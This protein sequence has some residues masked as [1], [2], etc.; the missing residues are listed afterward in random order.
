MTT[1]RV[2]DVVKPQLLRWARETAGLVPAEAAK[3]IG[4]KPERLAEW[5]EGGLRPTVAQ[6]RKA[7]NVYR[8]PFAAFFLSEPPAQPAPLHDFRRLPGGMAARLSPELLLEMR[9]ARRRRAVAL[10]LLTDLGHAVPEFPLRARLGDDPEE[11]AAEA[12]TWLGV[13]RD[14]QARWAGEYEPLTAWLT[15]LEA[16]GVLV[17]QTSD[18]PL[19]EMRGFSLNERRLPVI[20]LNAKDAPRGR[21]F[22][23]MH[24]F[25]HLILSQGGVCDP[26][27]L[28]RHARTDDERIEVYCN[29]VA[30]AILVPRD[31]LVGHPVVAP[32]RGP[33]E[34]S[35]E[36]LQQLTDEFAVSREVVLRRLL[37]LGRTTDEFYERK[38]RQYLAQ[39]QALASR[40]RE[41]EGFAPLFRVVVRDNGRRYTRLVLEALDRERITLADVS[42]YLGV[43]LKHLDDIA[44]AV[45]R[46]SA[47]G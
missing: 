44:G 5:E 15:V 18:V 22:T 43:R 17:F 33:R 8:R 46:V 16:R 1:Y 35:D 40:A 42:E 24:E 41:R 32:L 2:S 39:Y 37:I 31:A 9:R 11:V 6:L 10:D 19:G 23:L 29:R 27:R 21:A 26:L 12:R 45:E 3:K 25:T 30:G 47:A 38:R 14:E 7:A 34:W 20:V 36:A 4:V 13:S 28:G